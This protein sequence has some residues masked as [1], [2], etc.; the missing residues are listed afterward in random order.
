M[1]KTVAATLSMI[2]P[3][4]GSGRKRFARFAV[5]QDGSLQIF[6]LGLFMLMVM[7]GG[8]AVDLMRYEGTRTNLQNTLDRSTLAAA[9]LT[10]GL[11][12]KSVVTDYFKKA[13]LA[14]ELK[15]VTVTQGLNY[16]QVEAEALAET[17]PYFM[18]LMGIDQL[19]AAGHSMAEQRISNVEIML[20]LD[21]S[22]SMNSNNRLVNLKAAATEFVD[23][24]LANDV[25]QRISIGIVPFNGQINLGTLK[26]KFN[27]T[28]DPN[29]T[30]VNCVD[31]PSSAY[32]SS[33][34]SRTASMSMTANA[35]TYSGTNYSTSYTAFT[36]GSAV[37]YVLNTWCPP[38][39]GNVVRMPAQNKT[40]LKANINGL[41][42]VGAT[43]INAGMK[44]GLALVDP[45]A[46]S[47]YNEL[48]S[49]NAMPAVLAG[50]PYEYS[51]KE[52][53]KVIVLMTDGE[54]FAEERVQ[55]SYKTGNSPISRSANDGNYSIYLPAAPTAAK[56][57]V[58]H[59]GVFQNVVWTNATNSGTAD[60]QT[61]PQIWSNMRLTYVAWQFYARA[62]GTDD[63]SRGAMYD[64]M[65]SAFKSKTATGTMDSSL[66][67]ACGQAKSN[68]II[69]YGIAFEA[70]ANGQ[71]QIKTC[72]TS[73]SHYFSASGLQIKTAFRAIASNISQLRLTQ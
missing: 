30:D 56:Y 4:C 53:M 41:T 73:A 61:W 34:I 36:D 70:S 23:T 33:G 48:V 2:A 15:S 67:T 31:L 58:P 39:P 54:N 42:A 44:W 50:R 45:S 49:A 37:P 38:R 62:L 52:A 11:E 7:M 32:T 25:E 9:S 57:W 59:L 43:S 66:Q 6:A 26:S 68:E 63:P 46:R 12:P 1:M 5:Q 24:V 13:G 40:D 64:T 20:V 71:N 17:D 35:D 28:D 22:G 72:A 19:D 60:V 51:D 65:M 55:P 21:V 14:K 47:I 18:H 10:Q 27:L 8:L 29:I 69:V 3:A 16:K